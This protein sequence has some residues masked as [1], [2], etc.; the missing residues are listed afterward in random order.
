MAF[1]S[2]S[3]ISLVFP[4]FR[5]VTRRIILIALCGFLG[6][7]LMRLVSLRCLRTR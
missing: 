3:P 1:K 2:N 7:A 4:P 5:G 6:L